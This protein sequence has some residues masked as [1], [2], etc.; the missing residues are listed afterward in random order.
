MDHHMVV[1][2]MDAGMACVT[3]PNHACAGVPAREMASMTYYKPGSK[4]RVTSLSKETKMSYNKQSLIHPAQTPFQGL[5]VSVESS[6]QCFKQL[7]GE[8]S[9][10]AHQELCP[11]ISQ[12]EAH[13]G[14]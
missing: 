2:S 12:N 1:H 3:A 8:R 11:E 13:G 7:L 10:L 9:N 14:S 4:T 5:M 6:L